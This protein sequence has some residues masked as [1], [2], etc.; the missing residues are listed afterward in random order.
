M[1]TQTAGPHIND[2]ARLPTGRKSLPIHCGRCQWSCRINNLTGRRG[3]RWL[4][5]H[6]YIYNYSYSQGK[7]KRKGHLDFEPASAHVPSLAPHRLAT[8]ALGP[9]PERRVAVTAIQLLI[10]TE[11]YPYLFRECDGY[12]AQYNAASQQRY[13][14]EIGRCGNGTHLYS[15]RVRSTRLYVCTSSESWL[16]TRRKAR[17]VLVRRFGLQEPAHTSSLAM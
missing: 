9:S 11:D 14:L 4:V 8:S 15:V 12:L 13:E 16:G 3:F 7:A 5:V 2:E 10:E 1:T 6:S 17:D